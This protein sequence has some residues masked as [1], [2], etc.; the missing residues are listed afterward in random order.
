M[1]PIWASLM[2]ILNQF[3]SVFGLKHV[4]SLMKMDCVKAYWLGWD[5]IQFYCENDLK[6]IILKTIHLFFMFRNLKNQDLLVW[7]KTCLKFFHPTASLLLLFFQVSL[8]S[9]SFLQV[10][11]IEKWS[12]ILVRKKYFVWVNMTFVC[13]IFKI[14]EPYPLSYDVRK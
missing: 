1:L 6:G 10:N 4:I 14:L 9:L 11:H 5:L 12:N 2:Y 7:P 8:S 3:P 13:M